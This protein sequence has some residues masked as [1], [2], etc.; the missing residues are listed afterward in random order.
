MITFKDRW[1][2]QAYQKIKLI[3]PND[4]EKTIKH[5][6]S[7]EFDKDYVD[8]K[9]IIYNNYEKDEINT[10]IYKLFDWIEEHQPILT[11]SG[12]MFKQHSESFNP[13]TLILGKKLA[14]RK[15]EKK[16][17]FK[18][19][20]EAENTDDPNEKAE[21]LYKAKK[22]DLAQLRL[23]II[24]NSEYGV[25]GLPSSW[26]FNMAC[27]SATTARGQA[28]I[29]TAYNAFEDFLCDNVL[30]Y[31]MDECLMFIN[32]IVN[33]KSKRKKN[34]NK[35]VKDITR[36]QLYDRLLR[37]FK[38]EDICDVD[39]LKRIIKNLSQE[40]RN[41]IF[42]KSNIYEFFRNSKR[43]QELI[44]NIAMDNHEFMN[45]EKPPKFID[46]E[47]S[48][49]RD[50]VL[51]YVH[52]NYP[53]CNRVYRLKTEIRK[54]VIV[55][56]TDS[57]FINLNP[58]L[59]FVENEILSKYIKIKRRNKIDGR[60]IINSRNDENNFS[61]KQKTKQKFR[62]IYTMVNLMSEMV[63]LSLDTFKN[64]SNI[65]PGHPGVLNMKNEFLY[66][67]ILI[68]PAKKHYQSA[69]RIQEGVYFNKPLFDIKGMEYTKNSMAGESTRK[70]IKNLVY[71]DILM[72]KD[73]K[74]D[75]SKI[76]RKLKKFE[77]S[78]K[79]S[80][81]RGG[82]EYIK[83]ANI[84]TEDAYDDPMSIGTYKA[85]YVWNYLYPN[86]QIELP[87]I[88]KI[89]KV[90]LKKPKDFASM[91]VTHPKIFSKL[92]ELFNENKRIEKSGITNIAIPMDEEFPDWIIPYINLDEILS[93]NCKLIYSVLNC[94]GIKTIYKTKNNQFFSNI[95]KL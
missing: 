23:K 28:L 44:T 36:T 69:I 93:N 17:K 91:S 46:G 12:S 43:A 78:I 8:N 39:L 61:N 16:K 25:S 5:F 74:P 6:L 94:L 66:D 72:A 85:A 49:L 86:K 42:Y 29:S 68:T 26:F 32:N 52:Y 9:C 84:K 65:K 40:D 75:I 55:I 30:F 67:S 15:I 24:A 14:D 59:E 73:C 51:E 95:I 18:Y 88:A 89:V 92:M 62:I 37:K 21:L 82:D 27:A 2:E 77:D 64:R 19:L 11:E 13:N 7:E 4:D 63:N 70:F 54:C 90:N 1:I 48:K 33:E 60:Y 56:D 71:N 87:G 10:S 41:R 83:T 47:L 57:N 45:P 81:L 76:L 3:Y 50:A 31:N 80:V 38:T 35:W 79:E 58:W 34:D 20:S 53:T 22:A